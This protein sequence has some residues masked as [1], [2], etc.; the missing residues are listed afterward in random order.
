LH[1]GAAAHR[2]IQ[3]LLTPANDTETDYVGS[4]AG[5]YPNLFCA[6]PPFQIDG[7]FGSAAGIAEM[8]LQSHTGELEVLPAIP[9]DWP[10]G[11]VTG[12]RARG[13]VTVDL[14]WSASGVDVVLTADRDREVVVRRG[15]NR[16]PVALSAGVRSRLGSVAPSPRAS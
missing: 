9:A 6:H 15:D 2:L 12:L 5:L 1:D 13:G 14:E 10:D 3:E 7:N 4:G 11:K 16:T 8:L